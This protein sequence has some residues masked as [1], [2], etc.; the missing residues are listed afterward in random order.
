VKKKSDE[1]SRSEEDLAAFEEI[2]ETEDDR[3]RQAGFD[4]AGGC[5]CLICLTT[6]LGSTWAIVQAFGCLWPF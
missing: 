2:L 1:D 4:A 3:A 5:G 6:A